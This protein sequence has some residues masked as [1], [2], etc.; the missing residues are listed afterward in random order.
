MVISG[1]YTCAFCGHERDF[2]EAYELPPAPYKIL[3]EKCGAVLIQSVPEDLMEEWAK[4]IE[5]SLTEEEK[6]LLGR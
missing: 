4:D 6:K 5:A 3:C 2:G 1:V